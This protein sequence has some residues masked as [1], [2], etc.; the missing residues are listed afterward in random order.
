MRAQAAP[1][2]GVPASAG[3]A[4][5]VARLVNLDPG[6]FAFSIAGSAPWQ[7]IAAGEMEGNGAKARLLRAIAASLEECKETV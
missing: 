5:V 3:E 2:A 6:L 4:N 7:G 1:D